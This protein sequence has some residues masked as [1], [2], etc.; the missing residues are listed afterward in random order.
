MIRPLVEQRYQPL[1]STKWLWVTIVNSIANCKLNMWIVKLEVSH[2]CWLITSWAWSACNPM[3]SESSWEVSP[4]VRFGA[5]HQSM[6]LPY[7][8]V[9]CEALKKNFF[10]FSNTDDPWILWWSVFATWKRIELAQDSEDWVIQPAPR[11]FATANLN[12]WHE[13]L[14]RT[15]KVHMTHEIACWWH[16]VAQWISSMGSHEGARGVWWW[17]R[18]AVPKLLVFP[19]PKKRS[20]WT[21]FFC[22]SA[23]YTHINHESW[24]KIK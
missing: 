21:V 4:D 20:F 24:C 2:Y 17:G 16:S 1:K 15:G 18:P 5:D 23:I 7:L 11:L 10:G 13:I 9:H 6:R 3:V 8:S 22:F 12:V 14:H 19:H